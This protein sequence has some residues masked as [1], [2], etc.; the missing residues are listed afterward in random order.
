MESQSNRETDHLLTNGQS[1]GQSSGRTSQKGRCSRYC[2]SCCI[3][4]KGAILVLVWSALLHSSGLSL[5]V[6]LYWQVIQYVHVAD[7]D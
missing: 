6:T 5:F 2:R 3:P 1:S 4:F 7:T